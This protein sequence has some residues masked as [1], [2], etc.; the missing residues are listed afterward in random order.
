VAIGWG[1]HVGLPRRHA[2]HQQ[3]IYRWIFF[4]DVAIGRGRPM[5]LPD[6]RV[7]AIDVSGRSMCLGD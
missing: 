7:W 1:R 6:R 3:K 4:V 5:C 2:I